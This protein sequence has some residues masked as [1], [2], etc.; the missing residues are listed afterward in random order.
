M[1]WKNSPTTCWL[2]WKSLQWEQKWIT[3]SHKHCLS[4]R[5][6]CFSRSLWSVQV[7]NIFTFCRIQSTCQLYIPGCSAVVSRACSTRIVSGKHLVWLCVNH[8]FLE[9]RVS[10]GLNLAQ[11]NGPEGSPPILWIKLQNDGVI[12]S[13]GTRS[14]EGSICEEGT[15]RWTARC[16]SG[17]NNRSI[18]WTSWQTSHVKVMSKST[19]Q[20]ES[21]TCGWGALRLFSQQ[22]IYVFFYEAVDSWQSDRSDS[23]CSVFDDW[24]LPKRWQ[25]IVFRQM[26]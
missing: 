16:L 2:R 19:V 25:W 12:L 10:S 4:K 24:L 11:S 21:Y 18:D 3:D 13:C 8:N 14:V 1:S 5:T 20:G 9:L 26:S 6:S 15:V 23:M 17:W 22:G 7:E